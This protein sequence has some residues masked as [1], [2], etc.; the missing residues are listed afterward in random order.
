MDIKD[1]KTFK[2]LVATSVQK[3]HV[4]EVVKCKTT[5]I[6]LIVTRY[7]L[8]HKTRWEY[9]VIEDYLFINALKFK[10]IEDIEFK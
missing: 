7:W 8:K 5:K 6:D 3:H 10:V 1:I 2:K 9:S 4:I